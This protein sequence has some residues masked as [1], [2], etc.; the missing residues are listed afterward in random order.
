MEISNA[1]IALGAL[2]QDNRL[3]AY[4]LLV[5]AGPDG[6]AAGEV[7]SRLGV[8]PNTLTFHFDRLR[9]AGLV[10]VRRDGRS[11][12]YSARYDTM[13]A[14]LAYLTENCCGGQPALCAPAACEPA[15]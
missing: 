14:L 10:T 5:Q 4:R 2:A 6:M 1:V 11:M 15:Q 13:N 7:A 3:E 12:I 8:P 9:Q